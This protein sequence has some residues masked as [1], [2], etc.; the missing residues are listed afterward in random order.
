LEL[1]VI[2]GCTDDQ[3]VKL[4]DNFYDGCLHYFILALFIILFICCRQ[5]VRQ[6]AGEFFVTR[7]YSVHTASP[8]LLISIRPGIITGDHRWTSATNVRTAVYRI[9]SATRTAAVVDF[10]RIKLYPTS[11]IHPH[12]AMLPG[13]EKTLCVRVYLKSIIV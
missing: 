1:R 6:P 8:L 3:L 11:C 10:R 7:I 9:I 12:D 13:V 4:A 5:L 2:S